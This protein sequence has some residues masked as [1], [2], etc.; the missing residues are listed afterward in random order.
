[1]NTTQVM[2]RPA[3]A[4]GGT[5]ATPETKRR[6]TALFRRYFETRASDARE[7][8]VLRFMPLARSLARRYGR[9]SE[10]FDD[11]VQ[12]ANLAL[13]KAIDGFDPRRNRPFTAYAVPT[14]L[15]ELRRHFR[16][17][18][19]TL[20][21]PRALSEFT[22][23]LDRTAD[24]LADE[25]GRVPTPAQIADRLGVAIEEVL[26]GLAADRARNT[27]SLDAPQ[28]GEEESLP[29]LD[30]IGDVEGGYDRVEAQLAA[31][32]AGLDQR[33]WRVLRLRFVE[34]ITQREIGRR[35]GVSQ[36]QVSRISRR[37]LSKLLDSV[38]AGS[39]AGSPP[40][41]AAWPARGDD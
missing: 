39:E 17:N 14:I 20:R 6:E 4:S 34:D 21:L 13:V 9:S 1:M 10:S 26:E 33:E 19:W 8:L 5:R 25:L 32:D 22:M 27:R 29:V 41:S 36:M 7:E 12:V 18:V 37:A 24:A 3:P 16:D 31:E 15:G 40:D 35:L 2:A 11:L 30:S 23:E 38:G 28:R